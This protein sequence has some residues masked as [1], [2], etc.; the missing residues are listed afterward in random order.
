MA[1]KSARAVMLA[2]IAAGALASTANSVPEQTNH[3]VTL[4][5]AVAASTPLP[6]L[7]ASLTPKLNSVNVD[8]GNMHVHINQQVR[9]GESS[10]EV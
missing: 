1:N 8:Q 6:Y 3:Q 9:I 7:Q 5:S 2:A 4:S 10:F